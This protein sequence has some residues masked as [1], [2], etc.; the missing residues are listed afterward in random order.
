MNLAERETFS[1]HVKKRKT[2]I[3]LEE[4]TRK[5]IEMCEFSNQICCRRK[6]KK[7][8]MIE[9]TTLLCYKSCNILKSVN[10]KSIYGLLL[11]EIDY[12]MLILNLMYT[13]FFG[14]SKK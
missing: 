1:L 12:N 13:P 7:L 11:I 2:C 4:R 3:N 8:V 6:L 9:G 10:F 5:I 14:T